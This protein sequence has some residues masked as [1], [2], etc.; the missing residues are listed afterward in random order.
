MQR[1]NTP[2]LDAQESQKHHP[3]PTGAKVRGAVEFCEAIGLP[4]YKEDVFRVFGVSHTPGY[5]FLRNDSSSRRPHN[6]PN[7]EET[8]GRKYVI[9]PQKIREMERILEEEGTEA[10]AL[11]WEQLRQE[12]ELDYTGRTIKNAMG[13]MDYH[14]CIAC[15]K[16]WG[17]RKNCHESCEMGRGCVR[18]ISKTGRLT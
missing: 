18:T 1:P 5:D 14:K 8:R 3:T 17:N 11:M 10:R 6:D 7:R 12:G 4:H 16:R 13:T 15:K 9:S 2:D